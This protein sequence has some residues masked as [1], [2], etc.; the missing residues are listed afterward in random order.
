MQADLATLEAALAA[1]GDDADLKT[2]VD[3]MRKSIK[4]EKAW[5]TLCQRTGKESFKPP[6]GNDVSRLSG[7]IMLHPG[8]VRRMLRT[9]SVAP[10]VGR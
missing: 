2:K 3:K 7:T 4:A 8:N 6:R 5:E 1:K 10:R 9:M